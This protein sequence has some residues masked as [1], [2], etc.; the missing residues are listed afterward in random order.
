MQTMIKPYQKIQEA[1]R[2]TGLSQYMLRRGCQDGSV[3]H[4]RS[5]RTYYVN[6]PALLGKLSADQQ[7]GCGEEGR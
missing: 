4:V 7:G 6:V 3:P 5:G 1:C 2:T